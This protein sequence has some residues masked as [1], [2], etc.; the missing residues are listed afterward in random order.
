MLQ[1]IA[2]QLL[3][4]KNQKSVAFPHKSHS[5]VSNFVASGLGRDPGY[6]DLLENHLM[7]Y[8][9]TASEVHS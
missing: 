3:P 9:L 6:G 2:P 5:P 8:P 4:Q 1:T 7:L